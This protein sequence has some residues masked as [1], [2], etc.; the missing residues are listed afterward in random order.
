MCLA[1][2]CRGPYLLN[3][4]KTCTL[5]VFKIPN[6]DVKT[7]VMIAMPQLQRDFT[8]LAYLPDSAQVYV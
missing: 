2:A 4:N 3:M 1:F 8:G 6:V 5:Y 7:F